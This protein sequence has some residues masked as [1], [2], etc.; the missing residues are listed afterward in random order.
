MKLAQRP[1]EWALLCLLIRGSSS[2]S[3][4]TP[5]GHHH[6]RP[7]ARS[8]TH[9]YLLQQ[10]PTFQAFPVSGGC[11]QMGASGLGVPSEQGCIS[12]LPSSP[13]L[14][15][16]QDWY[17]GLCQDMQAWRQGLVETRSRYELRPLKGDTH[18]KIISTRETGPESQKSQDM[19]L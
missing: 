14:S 12:F 13:S 9:G 6:L 19:S 18:G 3:S 1:A 8:I 15:H 10:N 11:V 4:L 16:T 7:E 17:T 5:I 2:S